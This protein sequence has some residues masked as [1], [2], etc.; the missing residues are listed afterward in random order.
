MKELNKKLLELKSMLTLQVITKEE[1]YREL[2]DL[3]RY[4]NSKEEI[5]IINSYKYDG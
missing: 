4:A 5:K 2:D 1:Y 3:I